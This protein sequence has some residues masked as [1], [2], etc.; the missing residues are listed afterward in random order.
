MS[1]EDTNSIKYILEEM[2]PAEE[3]EFERKMASNPDL[4]IEV[5]SIRRMKN[6]LNALPVLS[7]PRQLT[8]SILS[9]ASG[10]SNK[11][12]S[13][14]SGYF[15][16]AAVVI[17]GLT[18]GSLIINNSFESDGSTFNTSTAFPSYGN[19]LIQEDDI[20]SSDLKPWVDRQDVLHLSGFE[21]VSNPIMLNEAGNSFN[22]LRPV[23][24][25]PDLQ[26]FSRSVQ[27]T[28]NN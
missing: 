8:D 23:G 27:L 16:S 7:P 19:E 15:L 26:P 2:D 5:E 20:K 14:R 11:N 13:F 17:L 9:H 10:R 21:S 6:K 18:T 12:Q 22:K 25:N 28:G 1:K 3:V 4:H 24:K